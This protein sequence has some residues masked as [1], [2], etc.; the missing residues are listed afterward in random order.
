MENISANY[1]INKL[2]LISHPEGGF[3]KETY[4][5]SC[6]IDSNIEHA[7]GS[8]SIASAIYYLLQAGDFSAFHRLD[9]DEMWHYYAGDCLN[10]YLINNETRAMETTIIGNSEFYKHAVFQ[11][12]VPKNT[13]FAAEPCT[14]S[15]YCLVGATVFP[16]FIFKTFELAV[17][18]QLLQ[19]YPE[20]AS[21]ISKL[22][23]N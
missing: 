7:T 16:A 12:V 2:K 19:S 11:A 18:Q 9:A 15:Q 23:R 14:G 22:T 6:H 1:W 4:K 8:R 10:L 13:W 5:S 21:L 3:Y 20:H 17:T